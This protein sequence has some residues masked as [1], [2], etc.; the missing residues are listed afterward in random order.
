ME[1]DDTCPDCHYFTPIDSS[2]LDVVIE[3]SI[4]TAI[5]VVE[6]CFTSHS[7]V[8]LVH[9]DNVKIKIICLVTPV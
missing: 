1:L 4:F 6:E 5:H 2:L 8:V 3:G 9:L 7:V